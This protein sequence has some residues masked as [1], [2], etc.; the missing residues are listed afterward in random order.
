MSQDCQTT[1]CQRST[2]Q[3]YNAKTF[4]ALGTTV[5][6][7]YGDSTSG[8]H[9]SGPVGTDTVTLAALTLQKQPL[10]AINDTDN[11]A[12]S[13]GGAGILGLGFPGQR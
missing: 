7:R 4:K 11:S 8:T 1:A 6:L 10:G 13:N 3:P 5:S 9:A 12:V 2:A